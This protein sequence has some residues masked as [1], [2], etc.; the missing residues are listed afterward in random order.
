MT[1][2]RLKVIDV[3]LKLLNRRY[4]QALGLALAFHVL[5]ALAQADLALTATATPNSGLTVGSEFLV[6]LQVMNNGPNAAQSVSV[7]CIGPPPWVF[8]KVAAIETPGCVIEELDFN[9]TVF[10]VFW[11]IGG[12][13]VASTR[14][15]NVRLRLRFVPP[16]TS[17][18]ILTC[19]ALDNTNVPDPQPGNNTRQIQLVLGGPG[20]TTTPVPA[21]S[22]LS[23]LGLIVILTMAGLSALQRQ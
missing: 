23:A 3:V 1:L 17:T 4:F 5:P 12:M 13:S 16:N 9:P 15:C 2:V 22:V 21:L 6:S 19:E 8:L 11:R 14:S 10:N 20:S 18:P 7:G